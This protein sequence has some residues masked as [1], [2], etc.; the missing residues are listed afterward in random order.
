MSGLNKLVMGRKI[1][2]CKVKVKIEGVSYS[3]DLGAKVAGRRLRTNENV[4]KQ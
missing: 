2:S 1:T 4:C 3:V